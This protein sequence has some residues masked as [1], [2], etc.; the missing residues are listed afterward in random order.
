MRASEYRY[1]T[2]NAVPFFFVTKE[3]NG[4]F[5]RAFKVIL[6]KSKGIC[7]FVFIL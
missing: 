3:R 5:E 2:I 7:H 1:K 6:C 4:F